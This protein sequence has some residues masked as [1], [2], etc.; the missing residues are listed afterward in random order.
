MLI[1]WSVRC[2]P[3]HYCL[4]VF[5]LD[6][7]WVFLVLCLRDCLCDT[8]CSC[9]KLMVLATLGG[10]PL[11]DILVVCG[12][13]CKAHVVIVLVSREVF[14]RGVVITSWEIM[15]INSS[16]VSYKKRQLVC[17][18][19]SARSLPWTLP[20]MGRVILCDHPSKRISVILGL[21]STRI[22]W[23]PNHQTSR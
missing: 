13:C 14:V 18:D 4:I 9:C 20:L 21:S 23:L 8:I 22:M 5:I 17:S 6:S 12:L 3:I 19:Q 10:C 11:L 2:S 15:K 16:W 1:V 7:E